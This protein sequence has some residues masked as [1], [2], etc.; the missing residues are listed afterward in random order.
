MIS[1][2]K[3]QQEATKTPKPYHMNV[4]LLQEDQTHK[5]IPK[6]RNMPNIKPSPKLNQH[7]NGDI[8]C[9][10]ISHNEPSRTNSCTIVQDPYP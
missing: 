2:I 10:T 9:L 1:S 5:T 4:S 3:P 7:N 6:P 8:Q